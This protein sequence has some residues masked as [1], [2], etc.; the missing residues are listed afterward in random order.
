MIGPVYKLQFQV[1]AAGFDN[2]DEGPDLRQ[3]QGPFVPADLGLRCPGP[4]GQLGLGEP[5]TR[6]GIG[7]TGAAPKSTW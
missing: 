2:P 5:R 7:N 3:D 6:S 4:L 1:H